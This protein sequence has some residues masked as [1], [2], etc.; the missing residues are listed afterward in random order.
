MRKQTPIGDENLVCPLHKKKMSEVCHKCPWWV[1]VRGRNPN[2]GEEVDQW[3]CAIAWG[4]MLAVNTAQQ[5]RETGAAVES[6]RNEVVRRHDIGGM[7]VITPPKRVLSLEAREA[8][9]GT[10]MDGTGPG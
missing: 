3:N 5:A 9:D 6:F 7:S 2:T 4:P 1:H 10:E 8:I